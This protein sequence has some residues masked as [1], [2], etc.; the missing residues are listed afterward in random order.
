MYTTISALLV[1]E[2]SVMELQIPFMSIREVIEKQVSLCVR[3]NSWAHVTL[4]KRAANIPK[5]RKSLNG[6]GCPARDH[7]SIVE[8][9]CDHGIVFLESESVMASLSQEKWT[10][11]VLVWGRDPRLPRLSN[12]L[13]FYK[14]F[15]QR[16]AIYHL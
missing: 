16:R 2:L 1:A 5:M 4:E 8:A 9:I 3:P 10:C 12:S 14:G 7:I 11:N 6:P 13:I 15:L